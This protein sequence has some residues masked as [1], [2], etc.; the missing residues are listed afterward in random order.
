MSICERRTAVL[1]VGIPVAAML[2]LIAG[3]SAASHAG[4]ESI[5]DAVHA[6]NGTPEGHAVRSAFDFRFQDI[7][8]N[9]ATFEQELSLAELYAERGIVLNFVASWC[10]P[11]WDELPRFQKLHDAHD[12]PIACIAADEYY[13]AADDVLRK[14]KAANSTLPL[15]FVPQDQIERMEQFYD[16]GMLPSTYVVDPDGII[17]HVFQGVI[18]AAALHKEVERNFPSD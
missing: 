11:C 15:L 3:T 18:S 6:D 5:A 8:P 17:R 1:R 14:T 13:G 9:S 12:V 16:H 7:N 10:R 4:G 2:L